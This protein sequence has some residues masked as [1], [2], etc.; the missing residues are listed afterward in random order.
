[1]HHVL[2]KIHRHCGFDMDS[3]ELAL[4]ADRVS[5]RFN[6][7]I[8]QLLADTVLMREDAHDY[9]I[10]LLAEHTEKWIEKEGW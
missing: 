7:P 4:H 8:P 1:M 6:W 9:L 2:G 5:D 3:M 10:S